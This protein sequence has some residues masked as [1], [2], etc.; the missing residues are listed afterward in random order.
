M[1]KVFRITGGIVFPW[2]ALTLAVGLWLLGPAGCDSNSP[3]PLQDNPFKDQADTLK[4]ITILSC[5]GYVFEL[6]DHV[7]L[8]QLEHWPNPSESATRI[9]QKTRDLWAQNGLSVAVAPISSWP[10]LREQLIR[11]GAHR[12]YDNQFW[13]RNPN[14][15]AEFDTAWLDSDISFFVAG[16]DRQLNGYSATAGTCLF[17]FNAAPLFTPGNQN[18]LRFNLVP[19]YRSEKKQ[20]R[21]THDDQNGYQIFR[22]EQII[23]F[24]QLLLTAAMDTESFIAITTSGKNEVIGNL[25]RYFL[26]NRTE[27][28]HAQRALFLAPKRIEAKRATAPVFRREPVEKPTRKTG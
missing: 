7:S 3:S 8:T 12:V 17:R 6:P 22:E 24:E 19:V 2:T 23:V 5:Q 25:G 10:Q 1:K 16:H 9:D 4:T 21:V 20:T 28:G 18:Q 27:K 26:I 11:A 14:E 15:L 13:L